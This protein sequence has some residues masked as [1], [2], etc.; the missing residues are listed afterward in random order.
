MFAPEVLQ[1]DWR[2]LLLRQELPQSFRGSSNFEK[3]MSFTGPKEGGCQDWDRD[4]GNHF[5]GRK[6][7]TCFGITPA[8]ASIA[9]KDGIMSLP[10]GV[11]YWTLNKWFDEDEQGF[12]QAATRVYEHYYFKPING[13]SLPEVVSIISFDISV[14]GGAGLAMGFLKQTQ[15]IEDPKARAKEIN[16]LMEAHYRGIVARRPDQG[17]FLEGWLSRAEKQRELIKRY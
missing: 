7:F 5:Q 9:S 3:A 8:T 17:V 15:H 16:R 6:G 2:S 12:K 13:D 11:D 10:S 1:S 4:K 14:N